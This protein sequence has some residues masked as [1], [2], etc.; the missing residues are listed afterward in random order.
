M[1]TELGE[2]CVELASNIDFIIMIIPKIALLLIFANAASMAS[3][4]AKPLPVGTGTFATRA[5]ALEAWVKQCKE[6]SWETDRQD[7][8]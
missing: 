4:A 6:R 1:A 7:C 2:F 3:A 8:S 5:K